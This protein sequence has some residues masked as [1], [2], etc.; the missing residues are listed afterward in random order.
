MES[1]LIAMILGVALVLATIATVYTQSAAAI[2]VDGNGINP[3]SSSADNNVQINSAENIAHVHIHS[4]NIHNSGNI[5]QIIKHSNEIHSS[6]SGSGT[7]GLGCS[8]LDP[9]C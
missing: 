4:F 9:R 2:R 3:G 6:N 5:L 1:K 8:P 7:G